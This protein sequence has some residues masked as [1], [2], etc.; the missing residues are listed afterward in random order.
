MIDRINLIGLVVFALFFI[1]CAI[2]PEV[3]QWAFF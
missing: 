1:L 2:K 3:I